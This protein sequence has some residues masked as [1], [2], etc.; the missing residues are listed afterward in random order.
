MDLFRT[1]CQFSVNRKANVGKA[2]T[3]KSGLSLKRK[4]W[5]KTGWSRF[6]IIK[7]G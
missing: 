4:K 2:L 1:V 7:Y 6:L 5:L 3:S